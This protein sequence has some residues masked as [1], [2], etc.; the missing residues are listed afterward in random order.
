MICE[1]LSVNEQGHLTLAG[2]DVCG[3]AGQYGT[4][5]FLMD[6]DRIRQN[7]RT[8]RAALKAAFGD[9]AGLLYAGKA[10]SFRHIY[11][12][13][14]AEGAGIDAVSAGELL[15]AEAAGFDLSQAYFHGNNKTDED[16]RLGLKLGTGCFVTDSEDELLV[17]EKAAA[18][19][20]MH[21]KILLRITPG[22]DPHTYAAVDTGQVDSKFGSA[23]ATGA[24]EDITRLALQQPHLDLA[25]F[26]CHVGSQLFDEQV[27]VRAASV[28]G[29]FAADMRDQLGFSAREL[30]LGGGFGIR[31]TEDDPVPDA[32]KVLSEVAEAL[33]QI[34]RKR[35]F[36]LPFVLFEPGRRL[37]ADAGLTV[38]TVGS[39]K[40]IPGFKTYVSVDG[41]M[42]DNP[43]YALYGSH[44][45]C[46]AAGKMNEPADMPCDLVGRL[47]ESGD[48]LQPG[49]RLPASIKRGDLVAVCTTGAY[50]YSMVSHYNRLPAPPVVMLSGGTSAVA[51]RRETAEDLLRLDV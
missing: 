29:T 36:P 27:P 35:H 17:L 37:V 2:Q 30:D 38:Y 3:L 48:I 19:A 45:T 5:L 15:T 6:E 10:C 14:Q 24:A 46:L 18:A 50:N 44:Y 12:I 20:G 41:G 49:I 25:G 16:I 31:Y 23:I 1:N 40:R 4:P 11:R 51:V 33:R 21:Q 8:F 9:G 32:G 26:H 39:V 43:R 13:M 22:I 28:L 7:I 47:C 34:S 42:S